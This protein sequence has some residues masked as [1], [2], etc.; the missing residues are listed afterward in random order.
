[1][2]TSW[3]LSILYKSSVTSKLIF[4]FLKVFILFVT[5]VAGWVSRLGYI[6]CAPSLPSPIFVIFYHCCWLL[7]CCWLPSQALLLSLLLSCF[8]QCY[9]EALWAQ[10]RWGTLEVFFFLSLLLLLLSLKQQ[11]SL[12]HVNT[13]RLKYAIQVIS[14]NRTTHLQWMLTA[15][16]WRT[17]YTLSVTFCNKTTL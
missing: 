1:M 5:P 2:L 15:W 7:Y 8:T 10:T 13:L 9:C 11:T 6:F 12:V 14:H 16:C 3:G 4:L 17:L